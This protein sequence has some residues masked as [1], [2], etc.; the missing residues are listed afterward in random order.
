VV[1]MLI[2]GNDADVVAVDAGV[3]DSGGWFFC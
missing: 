3:A 1:F 2:Y